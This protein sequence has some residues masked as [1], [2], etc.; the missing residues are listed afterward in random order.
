M[1]AGEL[2]SVD[3]GP[4]EDVAWVWSHDPARGSVVTGY[5][6]VPRVPAQQIAAR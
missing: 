1:F 6:I 2:L 4:T 5:T 3:V